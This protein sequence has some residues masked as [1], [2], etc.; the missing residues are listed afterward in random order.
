MCFVLSTHVFTLKTKRNKE[1][2]SLKMKK[3]T[4]KSFQVIASMAKNA[5]MFDLGLAASYSAIA[6]PALTGNDLVKNPNEF[7]R[8]T[9]YQVSWLGEFCGS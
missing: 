4:K 3:P 7:L 6:I 8:I 1:E 5:L 9:E 2:L